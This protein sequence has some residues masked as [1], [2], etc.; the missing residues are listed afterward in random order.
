MTENAA[1]PADVPEKVPGGRPP[2][3]FP[4]YLAGTPESWRFQIRLPA[5]LSGADSFLAKP[6]PILRTSIGPLPRRVAE[7]RAALCATLC[8]AVFAAARKEQERRR[9]ES[10]GR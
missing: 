3:R 6:A 1:V 8:R 10:N 4:R 9:M 2:A 7:R 5:G